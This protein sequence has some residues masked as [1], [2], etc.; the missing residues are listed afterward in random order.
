MWINSAR[1]KLIPTETSAF[2]DLK[3]ISQPLA[4]V[5]GSAHFSVI[6]LLQNNLSC[7]LKMKWYKKHSGLGVILGVP[8]KIKG[9]NKKVL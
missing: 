1:W 7:N 5:N 6:L 3:L 4:K 8:C 9:H 2:I